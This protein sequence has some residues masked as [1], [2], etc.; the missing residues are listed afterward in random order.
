MDLTP[1]SEAII[2]LVVAVITGV[3]IPYIRSKT[4]TEQQTVLTAL[5]KAA[6]T[7]AE[8]IY[9]GTGRGAEKKAYVLAWLAD[10]GV[11]VDSDK[12]DALVEA[13]VYELTKE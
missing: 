12:L 11:T 3:L 13:A 2:T 9:T 10:R 6:V 8:Q 1:I 4:T 5:I 7:A